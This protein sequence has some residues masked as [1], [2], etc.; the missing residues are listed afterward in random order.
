MKNPIENRSKLSIAL[1]VLLT[2]GLTGATVQTFLSNTASG[3]ANTKNP[4]AWNVQ[5][6][7]E[8]AGST[9]T[10]TAYGG[11]NV[12]AEFALKNRADATMPYMYQVV[13]VDEP[14]NPADQTESAVNEIYWSTQLLSGSSQY[15]SYTASDKPL[16][17]QENDNLQK[18]DSGH[19]IGVADVNSD[20]GN[21]L[22]LC[23]GAVEGVFGPGAE[24]EN[25]FDF[26]LDAGATEGD[27]TFSFTAQKSCPIV[28]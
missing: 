7:S 27:Y 8:V 12:T 26:K 22:V 2:V 17:E 16:F 21:E 18:G 15:G 28:Q 3:T 24:W 11:E 10:V 23:N 1:V 5:D 6:G 4:L 13:V 14:G 20:S 25:D 19:K 9:G